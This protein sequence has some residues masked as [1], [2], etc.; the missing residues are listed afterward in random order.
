[1][2]FKFIQLSD[3]QLFS[4]PNTSEFHIKFRTHKFSLVLIT[5]REF[6]SN[7]IPLP[8]SMAPMLYFIWTTSIQGN[9]KGR[10]AL[11]D[12]LEYWYL[13]RYIDMWPTT[14]NIVSSIVFYLWIYWVYIERPLAWNINGFY[15]TIIPL[16][17]NSRKHP[18]GI[19]T[20][21]RF[22]EIFLSDRR[23]LLLLWLFVSYLQEF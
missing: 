13:Q 12:K 19:N 3:F 1:M 7:Q 18:R 9:T 11:E 4:L 5:V 8:H 14:F 10:N 15:N 17:I 23:I 6:R 20:Y 2:N 21:F 22:S 16:K